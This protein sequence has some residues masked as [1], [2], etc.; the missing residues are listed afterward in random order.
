MCIEYLHK[1]GYTKEQIYM[2]LSCCPCEGRI[3]G[4]SYGFIRVATPLEPPHC[5]FLQTLL[6]QNSDWVLD[7]AWRD[8]CADDF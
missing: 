4:M 6:P 5:D 1:F 8:G 3:S 7:V 2:L